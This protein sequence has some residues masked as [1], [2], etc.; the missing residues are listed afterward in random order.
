MTPP[1]FNELRVLLVEDNDEHAAT[2]ARYLRQVE[3]VR[4]RFSRAASL[5]DGIAELRS[6]SFDALLLDLQ[7]PDSSIDKTLLVPS[8]CRIPRRVMAGYNPPSEG[9]GDGA[10]F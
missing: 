1:A 9:G 4:I 5:A 7:L 6:T 8:Q 3:E 10:L 2:I